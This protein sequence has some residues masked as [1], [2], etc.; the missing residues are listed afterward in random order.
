[1][2]TGQLELLGEGKLA[3]TMEVATALSLRHRAFLPCR[4]SLP[5]VLDGTAADLNTECG[6]HLVPRTV[7]GLVVV[8]L[9]SLTWMLKLS[10]PV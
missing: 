3:A 9:P 2:A 7:T 1:M 4:R 10:V 5:A 6:G 8:A